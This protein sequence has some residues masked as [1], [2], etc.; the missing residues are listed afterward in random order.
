MV[1][2]WLELRVVKMRHFESVA[3]WKE[4]I[5]TSGEVGFPQEGKRVG[6]SRLRSMRVQF[7]RYSLMRVFFR[8]S[9][10]LFESSRWGYGR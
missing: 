5:V 6:E 4:A 3:I 9:G 10:H 7:A 2:R 8:V 1:D